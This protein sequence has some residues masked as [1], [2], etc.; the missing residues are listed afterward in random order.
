MACATARILVMDHKDK[1]AIEN[2]IIIARYMQDN[3]VLGTSE[4]KLL[5]KSI[6]RAQNLI[7]VIVDY[8][9]SE[10]DLC[11]ISELDVDAYIKA[12]KNRKKS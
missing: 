2:L 12:L 4:E 10:I 1:I 9:D 7:G 3:S 5:E 8:D 11:D 6:Q